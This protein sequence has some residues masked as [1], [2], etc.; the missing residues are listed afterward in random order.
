[1]LLIP[2]VNTATT[3]IQFK[4]LTFVVDCYPLVELALVGHGVEVATLDVSEGGLVLRTWRGVADSVP[5]SLSQ[6][7]FPPVFRTTVTDIIPV[8]LSFLYIR[9]DYDVRH[10]LKSRKSVEKC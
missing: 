6:T 9:Q 2:T 3:K 7:V 10:F 8:L 5:L 4:L 1:M